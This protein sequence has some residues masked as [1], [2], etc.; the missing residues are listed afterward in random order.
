MMKTTNLIETDS[1]RIRQVNSVTEKLGLP[2]RLISIKTV[3]HRAGYADQQADV[4]GEVHTVETN[5]V[6]NEVPIWFR[7]GRVV[8]V[9]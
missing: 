8:R 7:N 2:T 3:L 9:G 4:V 1:L 6:R 5:G